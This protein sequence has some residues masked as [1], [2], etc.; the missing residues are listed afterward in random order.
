M[1]R[2]TDLKVRSL[3]VPAT[4]QK[5]H[6]DDTL[7]GFGVRVSPGGT[8]AFVVTYGKERKRETLGIYPILSLAT[9]RERAQDLLRTRNY[10]VVAT[11]TYDELKKRFLVDRKAHVRRRTYD[12]YEWLLGRVALPQILVHI[13]ATTL[14]HSVKDLAP[15]VKS[16]A[17][18]VLKLLFKFAV[19]EGYLKTSPAETLVVRK[20]KARKRVLTDD[21]LKKVWHACP[22]TA[23]GTIVKLLILTGQRRSEIE[24]IILRD[25]DL[26]TIPGGFTK[27]HADH[28]FPVRPEVVALLSKD[29]AWSG[30]SKSKA[31]LDKAS[32]V[33]GWTLHD[34][35]RT[36][37]TK[38]AQLRLP[39]EVAEKYI[40][41]V[42]GVQDPVEQT[43]DQ[44]N[45]IPEMRHSIEVYTNYVLQNVVGTET[46][47]MG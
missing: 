11:V 8:K 27:N 13:S 14:T 17:T 42:S 20:S 16:H 29:R 5:I 30:W 3:P 18:A 46:E 34:L 44:H 24:Q 1:A 10:G 35:R 41:H 26:A 43:Y 45:Y 38:W 6:H 22:D 36:F 4:G 37:R 19:T 28:V 15:S 32:G 33:T 7:H 25:G 9:A 21:E 39:R 40:N 2:L 12:S 31:D 23:F 47:Q